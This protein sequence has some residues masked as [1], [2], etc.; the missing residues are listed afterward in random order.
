MTF[1]K[2]YEEYNW[3]ISTE[4]MQK[5]MVKRAWDKAYSEGHKRGVA[6]A[7]SIMPAISGG[8]TPEQMNDKKYKTVEEWRRDHCGCCGCCICIIPEGLKNE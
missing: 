4:N 2:W 5:N 3:L 6:D 8:Y 7:F 1:E